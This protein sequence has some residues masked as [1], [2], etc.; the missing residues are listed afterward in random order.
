MK[1]YAT[2]HFNIGR[3]KHA[4]NGTLTLLFHEIAHKGLIS[5]KV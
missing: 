5:E 4:D 2:Q 3:E 1:Q